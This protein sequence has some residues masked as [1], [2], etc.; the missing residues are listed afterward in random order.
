MVRT[1]A[2]GWRWEQGLGDWRWTRLSWKTR[3]LDDGVR[4]NGGAGGRGRGGRGR[5]A[6]LSQKSPGQAQLPAL[7]PVFPSPHSCPLHGHQLQ[8]ASLGR[9][10]GLTVCFPRGLRH[11]QR[12]GEAHG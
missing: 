9:P 3:V 2:E 6:E 1:R 12:G 10:A 7:G 8:W 5:T 4:G 11:G